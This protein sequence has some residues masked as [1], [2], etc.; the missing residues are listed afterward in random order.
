MSKEQIQQLT[1]LYQSGVL[2]KEAYEATIANLQP[3][4]QPSDADLIAGLGQTGGAEVPPAGDM[5]G[6]TRHEPGLADAVP[7]VSLN[8]DMLGRT[9]NQQATAPVLDSSNLVG[10][11]LL[12]R[13]QIQKQIGKGSFGAVYKAYDR[14]KEQDVA[15]W[16][17]TKRSADSNLQKRSSQYDQIDSSK[18]GQC[19]RLLCRADADSNYGIGFGWRARGKD[20]KRNR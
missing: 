2:S 9:S 7:D 14:K 5:L 18:L 1:Q 3:T 13:F 20:R 19:T 17:D 4:S 15:W 6:S 8:D 11:T 12:E 16:C 10:Q